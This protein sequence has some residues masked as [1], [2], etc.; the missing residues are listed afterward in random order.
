VRIQWCGTEVAPFMILKEAMLFAMM[1]KVRGL[2]P[3]RKAR[4]G[5]SRAMLKA[6]MI[7]ISIAL[8]FVATEILF[9][10]CGTCTGGPINISWKGWTLQAVRPCLT[11]ATTAG[12]R[13]GGLEID[14][15]KF[16]GKLVFSKAHIPIVAVKYEDDVCGPYRDWQYQE[17][18]FECTNVTGPGQCDGPAITN[19]D[20]P[21]G[22]DTGSFCGVSIYRTPGKLILTTNVQ[23]GWY[24]YI[25]KW[26]FYPDGTFHPEAYFGAVSDPCVNNAHVHLVYWRLDMD[27]EGSTPNLFE[28]H[29][30][31]Q[32]PQLSNLTDDKAPDGTYWETWDNMFLEAPRSKQMDGSRW[33]RVR[34]T[35][36]NRAYLIYPHETYKG[37]SADEVR[38]V[39]QISDFWVLNFSNSNQEETDDFGTGTRYWGHLNNFLNDTV[40]NDVPNPNIDRVMWFSGAVLHQYEASNPQCHKAN[41]PWFVPDPKS[42]PW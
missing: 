29:N 17:N 21:D 12:G 11:Q 38:F 30:T 6:K 20:M 25:F 41:G 37:K 5:R 39:P 15:A 34:N 10:Q 33:W 14:N 13:G 26:L 2:F 19:C 31:Y 27:I 3:I 24:R 8:A 7:F 42:S 1:F 40:I 32:K 23:A 4:A 36:T 9:A 22:D 28:E 16:N 35:S 18:V